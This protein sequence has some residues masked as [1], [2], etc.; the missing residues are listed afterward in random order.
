MRLFLC[1]ISVGLA[2]S[3]ATAN[4]KCG[5]SAAGFNEWRDGVIANSER[6]GVKQRVAKSALG[7]VTYNP[8]V[9]RLDRNQK[10]FKLS[11]E[12][13]YAKRVNNAMIRRGKKL[14]QN[15][16]R[17]FRKIEKQYGVPAP[18]I[19]AIWG[20]ETNY[21]S[22]SGNMP[23]MRSLATLAYDCRRSQFFSNE[24]IAAL[25]I[26]QRGDMQ[27]AQLKGAWAGEI[28]QTQ[29]LASSYMQYAV[30]FDRN[31]RRDLIRSVPDVL[32]STANYLAKKGWRRGQPWGPGTTNYRVLKE[33]N[34]ASVYVQ[35][36]SVMAEKI[37]S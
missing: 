34:K 20:L 9:I 1:A 5:N 14:G 31:G 8:K 30:D 17:I 3:T 19:L 32:G 10:S 21:G 7:G 24:L 35:T 23:V 25:H 27:P 6:F 26:I 28:G 33:W 22:F 12:Q 36:I 11:F 15:Y 37:G 16:A 18:I 29:F 2:L 4:A 13:F